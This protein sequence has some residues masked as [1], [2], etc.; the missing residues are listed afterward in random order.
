[1]A[2]T[3]GYI[4]R[5]MRAGGHWV[6]S[7]P[8]GSGSAY[9]CD[10]LETLPFSVPLSDIADFFRAMHQCLE[11]A[12]SEALPISVPPSGFNAM[13]TALKSAVEAA[14]LEKL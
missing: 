3:L 5:T 11:R 6:A 14:N 4:V 8:G 9:V 7:V 1:M 12:R 10:S 13:P 2:R